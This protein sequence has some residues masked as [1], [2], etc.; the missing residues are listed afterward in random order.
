MEFYDDRIRSSLLLPLGDAI[1]ELGGL[2]SRQIGLT[3]QVEN[4]SNP[5]TV[6]GLNAGYAKGEL[7]VVEGN[8]EGMTVNPN[9]IYI[10]DRPPSDLKPVAGIATVS[11]GN[12]VSHVQLLA[13]NLGIP[14]AAISTDNLSDLK[15]FDGKEIFYAVSGSRIYQRSHRSDDRGVPRSGSWSL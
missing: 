13:R 15:A 14:N 5:S 1:G 6:R 10:F 2:V 3:S 8:A 4:V 7:V 11:E 9:K 12:L